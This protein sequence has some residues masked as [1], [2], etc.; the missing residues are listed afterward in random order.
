[1]SQISLQHRSGA[2]TA[3]GALVVCEAIV[4]LV[5]ATLHT[6]AFTV[7]Q[8]IP[9]MIVEGLCGI[10][11]VICAYVVLT[12]KASAL[13]TAIVVHIIILAGVLLG[14]AAITG[15]PGLRTPTNVTLHAM[16]LV[17]I[18]LALSLLAIP[19][20]RAALSSDLTSQVG[21]QE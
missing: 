5:A 21:K 20:M 9:A 10:G 2:V 7:P 4:F 16:M 13:T 18:V 17:L 6:G 15:S 3:F 8:L 1:M 14:V 12:R 11:C 19:G